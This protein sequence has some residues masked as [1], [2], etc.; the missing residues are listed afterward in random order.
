MNL[1]DSDSEEKEEETLQISENASVA[2]ETAQDNA[3]DDAIKTE[4]QV[5]AFADSLLNLF[6]SDDDESAEKNENSAV[7]SP[8]ING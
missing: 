7:D 2:V 8:Q 4:D 1:F 5:N 3:I 6:E